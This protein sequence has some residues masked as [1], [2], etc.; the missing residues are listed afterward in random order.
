[1]SNPSE[2]VGAHEAGIRKP[3]TA[4][5]MALEGGFRQLMEA[6]AELFALVKRLGMS[7]DD[8]MRRE[9]D[10]GVDR[11]AQCRAEM[12]EL[13]S[14]LRKLFPSEEVSPDSEAQSSDLADAM[15]TLD[16][17]NPGSPEW[18]PALLQV[19]ELVGSQVSDDEDEDEDD[20]FRNRPNRISSRQPA[21]QA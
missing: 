12:T 20:P 5:V 3:T 9:L 8:Q 15:A 16:A 17:I 7:A 4:E 18:G 1:M 21:D 6:H 19:S 2:G 14:S 10:L 11:L 13:C